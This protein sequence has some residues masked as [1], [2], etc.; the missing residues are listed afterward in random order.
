MVPSKS[1][2][3]GIEN[4]QYKAAE[5]REFF[6]RL[7]KG[8]TIRAVAIELGINPHAAYRWRREAGVS[9]RRL[10]NREY[11]AEEKAEF[12]R[13]L[14]I[15]QNVS[16][17]ARE[18]GFVRVTCYKWAHASGIFTGRD[19]TAQRDEFLRLR[20]NR[21]RSGRGGEPHQDRQAHGAGLG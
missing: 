16:A 6:L 21:H 11:S 13:L 18:L 17:V 19:S 7:D 1:R 4:K 9:T 12:F 14:A 2:K 20:K 5:R 8:G 10:A 15:R 3:S